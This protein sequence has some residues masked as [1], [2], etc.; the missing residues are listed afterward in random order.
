VAPAIPIRVAMPGLL[1][2][3]TCLEAPGTADKLSGTAES[4]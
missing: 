1:A 2:C 3:P 4:G